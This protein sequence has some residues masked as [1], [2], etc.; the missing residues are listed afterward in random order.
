MTPARRLLGSL[1]ALLGALAAAP[2]A[3]LL[4]RGGLFTGIAGLAG[5]CLSAL[6]WR[7]GAGDLDGFGLGLAALLTPPAA[8]PGLWYGCAELILRSNAQYGCTMEEALELVPMVALDPINRSELLWTLGGLIFLDL[9][10]A[11]LTA[12]YLRLRRAEQRGNK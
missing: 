8:L 12:R 4:L 3:W 5:F 9:L 7:L 11:L 1:L 2:L 6:G 10:C